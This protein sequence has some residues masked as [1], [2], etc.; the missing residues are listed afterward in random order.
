MKIGILSDTHNDVATMQRAL[1]Q[2]C[3]LEIRTLFHCGDLTSLEMVE[4]F[5]G[6]EVYLV[7]G[8]M[9]Q[10][11]SQAVS[12]PEGTQPGMHWLGNGEEIELDGRRIAI[13]HGDR[14]DV[15]DALLAVQPDY[16]LSGHTHHR[17]DVRIGSTRLINPGAVGGVQYEAR[18]ICVLDLASD[19]LDFIH[20]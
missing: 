19:Q 7:R 16:L 18:S 12:A 8:N 15:L 1:Q 10:P 20:V 4:H 3:Q 6:F 11:P 13:A 17:R 14:K 2:F 9:D 5:D